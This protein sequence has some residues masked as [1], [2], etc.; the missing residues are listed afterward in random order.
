MRQAMEKASLRQNF[1][2]KTKPPQAVFAVNSLPPDNTKGPD[3]Y[4]HAV[5]RIKP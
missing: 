3:S 2:G 5:L 4:R 1:Y